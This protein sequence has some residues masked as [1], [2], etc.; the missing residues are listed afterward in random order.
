MSLARS[1]AHGAATMLLLV[2]LCTPIGAG[3]AV[4][5]DWFMAARDHVEARISVLIATDAKGKQW[6]R[7]LDLWQLGLPVPTGEMWR[8]SGEA[9]V[10]LSKVAAKVKIDEVS[11]WIHFL[12]VDPGT[13]PGSQDDT[14]GELVV[15]VV[16]N[17]Q[18]LSRPYVLEQ[19]QG[20]PWLPPELLD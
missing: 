3:A 15:D 8:Y 2:G 4:R 11:Q 19:R 18:A 7:E 9:Y 1:R 13:G 12:G 16:V 20:I 6:I 17:R 10:P 5:E 14:D